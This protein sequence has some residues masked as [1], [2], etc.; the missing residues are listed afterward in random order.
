MGEQIRTILVDDKQDNLTLLETQISKA[1]SNIEI[2]DKA[3]T[4]QEAVS[5]INYWK[6]DLV[7]LDIKLPDGKGFDVIKQVDFDEFQVIFVT[8]FE[9]Y[10]IKAFEF[11]ALHYLLKPVSLQEL[12]NAL[13]RYED[14][15][16]DENFESQLNTLTENLNAQNSKIILPASDGLSVIELDDIVQL[17]S[18]NNYTTFYLNNGEK[19]VVSKP[20]S[21]YEKLLGD[22]HFART[23]N[24]HVV[25]LKYIKKY[26]RGR[27]GYV[28]LTDNSHVDVSEGKRKE[29]LDKLR[30]FARN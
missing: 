7:F 26:I 23:H 15:R 5:K 28:V 4:V 13:Y 25:N 29:F 30:K 9:E 12:E 8:A 24:K 17:E 16:R 22:L 19:I 20:I 21:T 11:S 10:A 18:S 2:L 1:S 14:S 6:P 27:G 3:K